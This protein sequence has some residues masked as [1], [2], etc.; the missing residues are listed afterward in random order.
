MISYKVIKEE[1]TKLHLNSD[2]LRLVLPER[3]NVRIQVE[4]FITGGD[5]PI[6]LTAINEGDYS[7][8]QEQITSPGNYLFSIAGIPIVQINVYSGEVNSINEN[9][10]SF[11][12]EDYYAIKVSWEE[13]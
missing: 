10:K 1:I 6:Y 11:L 13:K 5:C 4:G 7:I 8:I 9:E 3:N 2:Y 12:P